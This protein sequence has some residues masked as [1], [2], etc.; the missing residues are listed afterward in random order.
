MGTDCKCSF[1][2]CNTHRLPEDHEC[3]VDYRKLGK[4]QLEKKVEK[5]ASRKVS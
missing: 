5:V 4:Q 3:N 2:F 1:T